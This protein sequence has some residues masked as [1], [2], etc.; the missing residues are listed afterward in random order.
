MI[1]QLRMR[2]LFP[3]LLFLCLLLALLA[4]TVSAQLLER[5]ATIESQMGRPTS[6]TPAHGGLTTG[7]VYSAGDWKILI[8]Y[9]Q[10]VSCGITYMKKDESPL[11]ESQ[12]AE[13]LRRNVGGSKWFRQQSTN[14]DLI[15]YTRED[16]KC[17]AALV[18]SSIL[19]VEVPGLTEI[20]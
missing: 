1:L 12:I 4:P 9:L 7:C 8:E 20:P 14:P 17:T 6:E 5:R 13:M 2:S 3:T 15:T 11:V 10:G 16:G 18:L 19:K